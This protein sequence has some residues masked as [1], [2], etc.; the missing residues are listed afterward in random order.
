MLKFHNCAS[1][2]FFA[3]FSS[4]KTLLDYSENITYYLNQK[5]HCECCGVDF[6]KY[7]ESDCELFNL[8]TDLEKQKESV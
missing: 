1:I 2:D 4:K 8:I 6:P 3:Q 7:H 5:E